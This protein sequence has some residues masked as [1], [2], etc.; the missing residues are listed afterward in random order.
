MDQVEASGKTVEDA[1]KKALQKLGARR[2]QVEL[3]VLDEGKKGFLGRGGRD[4]LVRVV[5]L[6]HPEPVEA[7]SRP[8]DT[9]IPRAA[10]A[11]GGRQQGQRRGA[12]GGEARGGGARGGDRG[13]GRGGDRTGRER[14]PRRSGY[15]AAE[16]KLTEESFLRAPSYDDETQPEAV[17]A[18]RGRGRPPQP[19][20]AQ[21][22][23]PERPERRR[24][25]R[26]AEPEV[27][28][29]INAE[30]V[31][32]AAH[33]TD[34]LLRILDINADITIRE[35]LTPGD[36]KGAVLAVLDIGGEDL[37]LLIGRRG[38]TLIAL[39][40]LVNLIVTRRYPGR[41]GV[42]IDVEHYRHRR[43]EQV[44]SL[45]QRMADRVRQTG[46]PIT[47]EPM[48]AAERRLVHLALAEDPELETNS[49]GEGDN[50]KVVIS[51]RR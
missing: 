21:G 47:L 29:D 20:E 40:Y 19:R 7:D 6:E 50:R 12:R 30:E 23:R 34:D 36:G 32:F 41:P 46:S 33:I 9:R 22:E 43:E 1:L 28:A 25:P 31:D 10:Q 14:P 48:T 27:D 2:E 8:P 26:E 35:P 45:A 42:T 16:P 4:A 38:E 44:V 39:Q 5:R 18:A 17:P 3:T 13:P 15:E 37:G 11:G 24:P 49:I 51:A